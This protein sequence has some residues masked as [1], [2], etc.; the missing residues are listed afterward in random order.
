MGNTIEGQ[1]AQGF[2]VIT[3]REKF[4]K[5]NEITGTI[6]LSSG[7]LTRVTDKTLVDSLEEKSGRGLPL[8]GMPSDGSATVQRT[9]ESVYEPNKFIRRQLSSSGAHRQEP[10]CLI[11]DS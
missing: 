7:I 8:V 9:H 6:N 10:G 4:A 2:Y 11:G 1:T 5:M 3:L